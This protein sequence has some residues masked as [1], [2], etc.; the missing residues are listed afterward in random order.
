MAF[1]F[2]FLIVG[3]AGTTSA[4]QSIGGISKSVLT[5]YARNLLTTYD[6]EV[7][8]YLLQHQGTVA[9]G[10]FLLYQE[11]GF[12]YN[13]TAMRWNDTYAGYIA[14]AF[15]PIIGTSPQLTVSN[16]TAVAFVTNSNPGFASFYSRLKPNN[17]VGFAFRQGLFVGPNGS[18]YMPYIWVAVT[19]SI[20]NSP[21]GSSAA[22]ADQIFQNDARSFATPPWYQPILDFFTAFWL[23]I[24]LGVGAV[25]TLI[26][27]IHYF[28]KEMWPF[29]RSGRPSAKSKGK[30]RKQGADGH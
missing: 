5:Q 26:T 18:G 25:F 13:V 9:K 29:H 22:A 7:S 2:I 16:T 19:D 1:A 27:G 11:L 17:S 6:F 12:S 24:V 3:G 8:Q 21:L 28:Y 15:F 20:F 23:Y 30:G 14:F 10:H 4:Q